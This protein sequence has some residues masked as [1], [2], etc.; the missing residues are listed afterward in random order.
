MK[1]PI[2]HFFRIATCE[3]MP[4][5]TVDTTLG[6]SGIIEFSEDHYIDC[7]ITADDNIVHDSYLD[8]NHEYM[9]EAF[10]DYVQQQ[11]TDQ[12]QFSANIIA[13]EKNLWKSW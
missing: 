12:A 1:K 3:G 8:K 10:V 6:F 5:T 13:T 11:I 9:Y 7:E 4:M 2:D